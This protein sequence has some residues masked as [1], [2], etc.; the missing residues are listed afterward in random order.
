MGAKNGHAVLNIDKSDKRVS[1]A[2]CSCGVVT[3]NGPHINP[4]IREMGWDRA[5]LFPCPM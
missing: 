2:R 1:S 4:R 3:F 5:L